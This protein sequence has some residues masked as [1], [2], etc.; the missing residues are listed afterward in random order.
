MSNHYF[1]TNNETADT[2]RGSERKALRQ[3][4]LIKGFFELQTDRAIGFTADELSRKYSLTFQRTP[5]TSLRRSLTN[6]TSDKWGH[7]LIKSDEMRLG[8]Y[9]KLTHVYKINPNPTIP[10]EKKSKRDRVKELKEWVEQSDIDGGYFSLHS[11]KDL[12]NKID[13]IFA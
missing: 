11:K 13:E 12:L 9:G 7:F 1:N 6:L 10:K 4:D 8:Q 5:T 3:E 2:L